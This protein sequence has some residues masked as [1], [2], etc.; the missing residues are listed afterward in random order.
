MTY[1]ELENKVIDYLK[2]FY[3]A[4]EA[5]SIQ[6]FL[7]ASITKLEPAA[8]LLIRKDE[9]GTDVVASVLQAVT[10]LAEYKP[11]Q[12]VV[13]KTWFCGFEFSVRPGVLIPRPETEL[14]VQKIVE[15]YNAKEKLKLLDVGT[16]SGAIAVSLGLM[17]DTPDITAIDISSIALAIAG[18]NAELN[19]TH[20]NFMELDIL[21]KA[22]WNKLHKFNLIVSNPPYVK[23]SERKLMKRNVLDFEPETAL[24]VE[25]ADPLIFYRSIAEFATLHLETEGELWFEIN[26][27][28]GKNISSLL[29]EK[30]FCKV[31]IYTDL[32]NKDRF[33]SA[34]K[35][36]DN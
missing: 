7:F 33:V 9:A 11:I 28:E 36:I 30:G 31:Q 23:Q 22:A 27:E 32:N 19:H 12:Y 14:L 15:K 4:K 13:G 20:I 35:Y 17:M 34:I 18:E 16:G 21:N 8:Y 25:D 1:T 5:R 24:F 2:D 3:E 29:F 6:R 10:Q 26:E